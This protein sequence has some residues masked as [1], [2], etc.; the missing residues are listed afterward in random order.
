MELNH[1]INIVPIKYDGFHKAGQIYGIVKTRPQILGYIYWFWVYEENNVE[2]QHSY[3]N[4][5]GTYAL[6]YPHDWENYPRM[7]KHD[8]KVA[9]S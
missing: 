9:S 4:N 6:N 3:S 1:L 5:T 2:N 7:Q 8:S